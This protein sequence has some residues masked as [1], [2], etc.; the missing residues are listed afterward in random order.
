[1]V[2]SG[3]LR[4]LKSAVLSATLLAPLIPAVSDAT[5][6]LSNAN[7][8]IDEWVLVETDQMPIAG[9]RAGASGFRALEISP[10]CRNGI[11]IEYSVAISMAIGQFYSIFI[12]QQFLPG[13]ASGA[14][15]AELTVDD[16]EPFMLDNL[17]ADW[18]N[19]LLTLRG[20]MSSMTHK[21]AMEKGAS[22]LASINFDRSTLITQSFSLS[23]SSDA[24]AQLSCQ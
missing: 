1:M 24:L 2:F 7:L 21:D 22:I 23:G 5:T 12:N 6:V 17:S 8:P 10:L 19:G 11:A 14:V 20:T 18:A 4:L 16:G 9:V 15:T 3:V 13:L